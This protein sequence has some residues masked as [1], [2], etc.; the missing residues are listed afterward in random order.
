LL[1]KD[2]H[3]ATTIEPARGK[4]YVEWNNLLPTQNNYWSTTGKTIKTMVVYVPEASKLDIDNKNTAIIINANI[5]T[6][7][8]K[9]S[10]SNLDARNFKKLT[11]IA[12]YYNVNISDVEEAE[13]ELE[14]GTFTAGI[15]NALDIDSEG[16]EIEY[17]SGNSVYMRSQGDRFTI[18]EI[19]KVDGRKL[20]GE[21]RIG[22]L[23]TSLDIEGMNADIKIRN[24]NQLVEKI[25]VNDK[26]A[27]LRLPVKNLANYTVSF[28]GENATVFAP[29]DKIPGPVDPA[30]KTETT[31][32][33]GKTNAKT[34]KNSKPTVYTES[35][36]TGVPL[37]IDRAFSPYHT[38]NGLTT[39]RG[40]VGEI[41]PVKFT[42][43]VGDVASKHTKF[44]IVCH[45][46]S[47]DFK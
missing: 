4:E 16:S 36:L 45:Q 12:D 28:H 44:E 41:S 5:G 26:Y 42:A 24:I 9:L 32:K 1:N 14:N 38:F 43:T 7:N 34:E 33:V 25:K 6:A 18:D 39:T 46:C 20:Y 17:E 10:H 31:D 47:V 27:D 11:I 2:K 13:L 40:F 19:G 23:L 37:E 35:K 15:I 22:K 8:F 3:G 30:E 29:F 21:L